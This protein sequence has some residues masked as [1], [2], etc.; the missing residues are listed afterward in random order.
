MG[1]RLSIENRKFNIDYYGTKLIGYVF[2][3]EKLNCIKFLRRYSLV[4]KD[5]Q[6]YQYCAPFIQLKAKDTVFFLTY[7]I[8]DYC[9]TYNGQINEELIDVLSKIT[10]I[11]KEFPE[12]LFDIYWC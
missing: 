1:Y 3:E 5:S 2:D 11:S 4:S 10:K 12:T 7:Y 8:I 6:F 9:N